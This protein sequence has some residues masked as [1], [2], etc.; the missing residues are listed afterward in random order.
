[1]GRGI[2]IPH[3]QPT[4]IMIT[5]NTNSLYYILCSILCST[6]HGIPSLVENKLVIE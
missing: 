1:M 3:K 5:K 2:C 4:Q 6:N